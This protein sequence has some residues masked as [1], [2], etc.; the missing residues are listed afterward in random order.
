MCLTNEKGP[1]EE[2]AFWLGTVDLINVCTL[3]MLYF[4]IMLFLKLFASWITAQ[5][6]EN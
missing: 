3:L 4:E 1:V 5:K 2:L 6:K